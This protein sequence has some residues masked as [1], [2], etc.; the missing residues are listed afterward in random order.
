[1]KV[2]PLDFHCDSPTARIGFLAPGPDLVGHRNDACFDPGGIGK[3][4]CEGRL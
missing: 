4:L 3:V 2:G 1:L